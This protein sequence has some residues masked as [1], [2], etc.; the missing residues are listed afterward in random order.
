MDWTG[1][2]WTFKSVATG[3]YLSIGETPADGTPIVASPTPFEWHIWRA[4]NDQNTFR[5]KSSA[6]ITMR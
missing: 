1:K 5:Y 3:L 4:D 6:K 2:S